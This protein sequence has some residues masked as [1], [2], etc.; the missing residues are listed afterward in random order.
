MNARFVSLAALLALVPTSS[1]RA[2]ETEACVDANEQSIQLRNEH[3]LLAARAASAKC[4]AP[5]CPEDVRRVCSE[6]ALKLNDVIPSILFTVKDG[7]GHD[8]LGV[9]VTVDGAPAAT[10]PSMNSLEL[11]PGPHTFVFE[12]AGQRVEQSFLLRERERQ[13]GEAIVLGPA[14]PA[15]APPA[16]SVAPRSVPPPHVDCT[17]GWVVGGIGVASL[18]GGSVAGVLALTL[19]ADSNS[20]CPGNQCTQAGVDKNNDAIAAAWVSDFGIGIGLVGVGVATY[21]LLRSGD[22]APAAVSV[23][24][25]VLAGSAGIGL[26]AIW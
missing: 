13:R 20:L 6:R 19:R 16:A 15:A 25:F 24:P 4:A 17:A 14:A 26:R 23:V 9:K 2:D 5:S 8:V 22:Q 18:V 12:A 3:K 10:D 11:D 7:S 21:L 1:A